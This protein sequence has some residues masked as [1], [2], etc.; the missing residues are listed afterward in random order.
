MLILSYIVLSYR[1]SL[2]FLVK[3][4]PRFFYKTLENF[5]ILNEI[6]PKII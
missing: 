5:E 3:Y 6:L 2:R 1:L 4:Q